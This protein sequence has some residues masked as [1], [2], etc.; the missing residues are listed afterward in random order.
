MNIINLNNI[1]KIVFVKKQKTSDYEW[2]ETT[3]NFSERFKNLFRKNKIKKRYIK[4]WFN[5]IHYTLEEFLEKTKHYSINKTS[6]IIYKKPHVV[7]WYS[8]YSHGK[9]TRYF[10]SDNEAKEYYSKLREYAKQFDIPFID[11]YAEK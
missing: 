1:S 6:G 11:F 9:E 4:Y 10:E 3:E 7:L 5:N 2:V 8:D